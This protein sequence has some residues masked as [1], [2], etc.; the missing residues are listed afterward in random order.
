MDLTK[1]ADCLQEETRYLERQS[2]SRQKSQVT[3]TAP[4]DCRHDFNRA[5]TARSHLSDCRSS[6]GSS[7]DIETPITGISSLNCEDGNEHEID[8]PAPESNPGFLYI[9]YLRPH[10]HNRGDYS[11]PTT[12]STLNERSYNQSGCSKSWP[13]LAE[14]IYVTS[15]WY[16]LGHDDNEY[17]KQIE[18]AFTKFMVSSLR[19]PSKIVCSDAAASYYT[20]HVTNRNGLTTAVARRTV[21]FSSV[22]LVNAMMSDLDDG[23]HD[24]QRQAAQHQLLRVYLKSIDSLFMPDISDTDRCAI[25][26]Q[27]SYDH[28][29]I[30][31][32]ASLAAVCKLDTLEFPDL[33]A[34]VHEGHELFIFPRYKSNGYFGRSVSR[35]DWE[36]ELESGPAWLRWDELISSFRGR[37]PPYS[38]QKADGLEYSSLEGSEVT[39]IRMLQIVVLAHSIE[40]GVGSQLLPITHERTIR[41]RLSIRILPPQRLT[42][43]CSTRPESLHKMSYRSDKGWASPYEYWPAPPQGSLLKRQDTAPR[44]ENPSRNNPQSYR[45][46]NAMPASQNSSKEDVTYQSFDS[47][48]DP[49]DMPTQ[50]STS[51][52]DDIIPK[53]AKQPE[54][55]AKP[56]ATT[57]AEKRGSPAS[58]THERSSRPVDFNGRGTRRD[59]TQSGS[60]MGYLSQERDNVHRSLGDEIWPI[61][62]GVEDEHKVSEDQRNDEARNE[63]EDAEEDDEDSSDEDG[64]EEEE[65]EEKEEE[66]IVKEEEEEEEEEED[67]EEGNES[68]EK[69]DDDSED[70]DDRL[71]AILAGNST[72]YS[73]QGEE[74]GKGDSEEDEEEDS[75]EESEDEDGDED[76]EED[77]EENDDVSDNEGHSKGDNQV[78]DRRD[79]A[80]WNEGKFGAYGISQANFEDAKHFEETLNG[81]LGDMECVY[82]QDNWW[83]RRRASQ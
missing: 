59:I 26:I 73:E 33:R 7:H 49:P 45:Y 82:G 75:E 13:P 15:C 34:Q 42:P 83:L 22:D 14:Q 64:N 3:S 6:V 29:S 21:Q 53:P 37:V 47:T 39:K 16:G 80:E 11:L 51:S 32:E 76:D 67:E 31:G 54:P 40:R 35:T 81:I 58:S 63:Q 52:G 57:D 20:G 72:G 44:P 12:W 60:Q 24:S 69:E 77:S 79:D 78:Y 65:E 27:A 56:W 50:C 70:G 68:D 41:A 46:S 25:A 38:G 19:E 43:L 71:K 17:L 61:I 18:A 9:Q 1:M 55:W 4:K 66:E 28:L 74:D 10:A 48:L 30:W 23:A 2:S 36:F 5:P 8:S 62:R